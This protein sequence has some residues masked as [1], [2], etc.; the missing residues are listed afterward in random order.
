MTALLAGPAAAGLVDTFFGNTVTVTTANGATMRY[1]FEPDHTYAL[2]T[3][4]GATVLGVW[5]EGDGLCLTPSGGERTCFPAAPRNV[6]DTW[7]GVGPDG[8]AVTLTLTAGR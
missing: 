6:G 4:D 1:H 7:Q 3:P 8:V 2:I 5:E